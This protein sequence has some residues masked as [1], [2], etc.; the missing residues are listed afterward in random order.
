MDELLSIR[1][2]SLFQRSRSELS[3]PNWEPNYVTVLFGYRRV[4]PTWSRYRI[5]ERL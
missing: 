5:R 2:A 4:G 1:L 3:E